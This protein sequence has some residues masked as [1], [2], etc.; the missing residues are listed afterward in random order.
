[1]RRWIIAPVLFAFLGLPTLAGAVD[2][3]AKPPPPPPG[4]EASTH[5]LYVKKCKSCHGYD[6]KGD[7]K[8]GIKT[9]AN[10]W[11]KPGFL[12]GFTDEQ[13]YDLTAKG[14]RKMPGYAKKLD[15]DQINALVEYMR[16]L[17]PAPKSTE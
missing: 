2:E 1:M 11:T 10:D 17:V 3:K 16:R 5:W 12:D 15:K 14:I 7:T 13:L 8:R 6:G 9:K 4:V